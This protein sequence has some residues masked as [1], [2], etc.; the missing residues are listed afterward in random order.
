MDLVAKGYSYVGI[1]RFT[2]CSLESKTEG[3]LNGHGETD[4]KYRF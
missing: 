4:A 3:K 1:K 2:G